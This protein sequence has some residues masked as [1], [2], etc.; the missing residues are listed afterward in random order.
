MI[1]NILCKLICKL[2]G[3]SYIE[4][5]RL[6]FISDKGFIYSSCDGIKDRI[7]NMPV[8][9]I[10]DKEMSGNEMKLLNEKFIENKDSLL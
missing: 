2:Y 7:I 10:C 1:K 6:G 8:C 9:K 4:G 5:K 3:H